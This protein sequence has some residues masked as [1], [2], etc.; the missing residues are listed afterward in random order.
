MYLICKYRFRFL[1]AGLIG[2]GIQMYYFVAIVETQQK[3]LKS[4]TFRLIAI[5]GK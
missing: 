1:I 2:N 3:H 4:Y 5:I